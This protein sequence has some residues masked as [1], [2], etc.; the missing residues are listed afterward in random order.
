MYFVIIK[1]HFSNTIA[2]SNGEMNTIAISNGAA[3]D[4][5][6]IRKNVAIISQDTGLV[7][8]S[9]WLCVNQWFGLGLG[10]KIETVQ[11]LLQPLSSHSD[12][13]HID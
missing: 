2:I 10:I 12:F 11:R 9:V 3:A 13:I 8:I 4:K 5:Y 6:L 7:L 1:R